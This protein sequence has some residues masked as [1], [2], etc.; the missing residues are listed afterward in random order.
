M[1]TDRKAKIAA[2]AARLRKNLAKKAAEESGKPREATD[3]HGAD[4]PKY[5]GLLPSFWMMA[6]GLT[7][8]A[9]TL[10]FVNAGID[11]GDAAGKRFFPIEPNDTLHTF[12]VRAKQESSDLALDVLKQVED[13]T[14][15]KTPLEGEGSYFSFPKREDYL[16]FTKTG[17]R[18]W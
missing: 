16:R 5:R 3:W 8:A 18:L 10:F 2:T 11:A 15:A 9:V 17:R 6:D 13:G 7:E 4:L 12:L 14:V 1:T